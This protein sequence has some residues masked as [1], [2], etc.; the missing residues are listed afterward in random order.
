MQNALVISTYTMVIS[1]NEERKW[2]V[3]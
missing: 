1:W 3:V 2:F